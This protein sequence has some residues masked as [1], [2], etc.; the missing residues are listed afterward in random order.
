MIKLKFETTKGSS[1]GISAALRQTL[2]EKS[3]T[4]KPVAFCINTGS[5]FKAGN[6]MV[7]M[8]LTAKL[9]DLEIVGFDTTE[10]P[11][12]VSVIK[13]GAIFSSDLNHLGGIK[14]LTDS[15]LLESVNDETEI[16]LTVIFD[17][18]C[19]YRS[20]D[21]VRRSLSKSRIDLDGY[22]IISCRHNNLTVA[23]DIEEDLYTDVVTLGVSSKSGDEGK[24]VAI[25]I[26]DLIANLQS[27]K[28]SI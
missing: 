25:A 24:K 21:E 23:V 4:V 8:D 12:K 19:G 5:Q 20:T 6:S 9:A 26:D 3:E 17:K 27:I 11:F 10:F 15:I 28:D 2:I 18:G 14:V 16:A 13:K 1:K 22:Y 7:D